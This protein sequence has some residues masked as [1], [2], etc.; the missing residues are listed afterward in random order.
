MKK[1]LFFALLLGFIWASYAQEEQEVTPQKNKDFITRLM[2]EVRAD[3]QFQKPIQSMYSQGTISEEETYGFEGKYF[4]LLMGGEITK[5]FSYYFRQRIKANAGSISFF[6]N[7]DF[8]YLNYRINKNWSLRIGKD[9]L[10]IGGFEYDAPPIDVYLPGYYW[11]NI[12]CFQIGGS[13]TFH[14]NNE[15]NSIT[16][17]VANSPYV[18]YGSLFKSSLLSYNLLWN[19]NFGP[20]KTLYSFS[21][22]E[23]DK[24]KFMN[25]I[26]LGNMLTFDRVSIYVDLMHHA[27]K[28]SQLFK[29]YAVI[30]RLDVN[31]AKQAS[32]FL[33]GGYEQNLDQLEINH[34]LENGELWDCLALPGQQNLFYGI[35]FEV[36]PKKCSDL[37]L[38]GFVA[39]YS[40]RNDFVPS[41]KPENVKAQHRIIANVG[42]TWKIDFV[43][44]FRK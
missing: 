42:A 19:G 35:G 30:G 15:K 34:Y 2:L 8:L 7:T 33:K 43:K 44:Y 10:M 17:Q 12:Y 23:R 37:R 5:N 6:D 38:H 22:F 13:V 31:V 40:L 28:M 16:L 11:D 36:Y 18:Y 27:N 4:N 26:A 32:L 24:G 25:Y 29:N 39:N 9:A 1:N 41:L 20:F 21:M 3:F 14:S